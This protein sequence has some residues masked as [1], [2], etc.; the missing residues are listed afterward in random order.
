MPWQ[1]RHLLM[2]IQ[3]FL[4]IK[5]PEVV[6]PGQMRKLKNIHLHARKESTGY[7]G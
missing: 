4:R 6:V 5:S 7:V 1:E 2:L 3:M